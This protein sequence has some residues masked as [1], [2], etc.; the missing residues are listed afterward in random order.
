MGNA[1]VLMYDIVFSQ[2]TKRTP[3]TKLGGKA[4]FY[5]VN[6]FLT[7]MFIRMKAYYYNYYQVTKN[8]EKEQ[9]WIV[10]FCLFVCLFGK[11]V[12]RAKNKH[13]IVTIPGLFH[14]ECYGQTHKLLFPSL[15]IS[16]PNSWY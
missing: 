9:M 1:H 12:G 16:G 3:V 4:I 13:G 10:G 7:D 5:N 2:R 15:L 8:F 11:E 14:T 6:V